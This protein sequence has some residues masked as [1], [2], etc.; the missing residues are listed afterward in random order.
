MAKHYKNVHHEVRNEENKR[1]KR[2]EMKKAKRQKIYI[3][4]KQ[5]QNEK[6]KK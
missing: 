2:K 5:W 6:E 4:R 3:L 1:K